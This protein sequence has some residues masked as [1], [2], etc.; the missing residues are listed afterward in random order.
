MPG[1]RAAEPSLCSYSPGWGGLA[2]LAADTAPNP[3]LMS[4][5]EAEGALRLSELRGGLGGA[6]RAAAATGWEELPPPRATWE[7]T[8]SRVG[9]GYELG[10]CPGSCPHLGSVLERRQRERKSWLLRM[11]CCPCSFVQSI[12]PHR[13]VGNGS[14]GCLL[15]TSLQGCA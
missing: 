2:G 3:R 15:K 13:K 1:S 8:F 6:T 12:N 4:S 5:P 9:P 10:Q 11:T 7:Y 14:G